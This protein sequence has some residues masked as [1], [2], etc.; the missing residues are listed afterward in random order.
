MRR[1]F[2]VSIVVAA[3][4]GCSERYSPTAPLDRNIGGPPVRSQSVSGQDLSVT[5]T[6]KIL[7]TSS[8]YAGYIS[9]TADRCDVAPIFQ[10]AGTTPG[11]HGMKTA[12]WN[13][14]GFAV[15]GYSSCNVTF[16][17]KRNNS[18]TVTVTATDGTGS[19]SDCI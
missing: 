3:M 4:L 6:G 19:G 18:V 13:V 17:D 10:F 8:N 9:A 12:T 2:T 5:V 11:S 7:T 15:C 16:T 1:I 14:H